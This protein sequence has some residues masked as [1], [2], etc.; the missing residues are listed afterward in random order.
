M[1]LVELLVV[2]TVLVIVAGVTIPRFGE[3]GRQAQQTVTRTNLELARAAVLE[4]YLPDLDHLDLDG[5]G[6]PDPALRTLRL[7]NLIEGTPA[8]ATPLFVPATG[9][10]WR[11][12][13]LR[14]QRTG[15]YT[16]SPARGF[17]VAYGIDGDPTLLDGWGNPIVVQRPSA[18]SGG[19]DLARDRNT[20]LVSAGPDGILD[21]DP[22]QLTP[23]DLVTRGD[24]LILFL[25]VPDAP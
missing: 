7:A 1:T 8:A 14:P 22:E 15:T 5:D 2:V 11:G 9:R 4:S 17:D 23:A 10:G 3:A 16:A 21:A 18:L 20:R 19:D 12:P 24:D 25:F 13:Y 6:T